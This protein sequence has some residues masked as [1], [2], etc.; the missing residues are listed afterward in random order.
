MVMRLHYADG[1]T[2]D[3]PILNGVHVTD[4]TIGP[5]VP[6]S[7]SIGVAQVRYVSI[8]PK[9]QEIVRTI[10]FRKGTDQTS[11]AVLAVTVATPQSATPENDKTQTGGPLKMMIRNGLGM[12]FVSVQAGTFWMSVNGKNAIRQE[13]VKDDFLIGR[14]TITQGQWSAVMGTNPSYFSRN[15]P[16][17]NAV[18]GISAPDLDRFPVER[19]SWNDVHEFLNKLNAREKP[20]GV[21]YRLPTEVEWEYACRAGGTAKHECEYDYYF[22]R[23]TNDLAA[24]DANF[25]GDHPGGAAL[26]MPSLW[27]PCKVG[28]YSQP[29]Q[30]DSSW[31]KPLSSRAVE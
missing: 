19:V 1:V 7:K 16:G 11:S 29:S 3:H 8:V 27:R 10:D 30:H 15:A 20:G 5:D 4:W 21:Q 2:E 13:V 9:R 17:K 25:L 14:Y 24:R 22:D 23:P 28:S 12:E 6:G 31:S 18:K 26:K